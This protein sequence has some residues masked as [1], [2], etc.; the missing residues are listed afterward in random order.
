MQYYAG[1]TASGVYGG[2]EAIAN[3]YGLKDALTTVGMSFG[4]GYSKAVLAKDPLI[5]AK[6]P[7]TKATAH[8]VP[9]VGKGLIIKDG[10]TFFSGFKK[11]WNDYGR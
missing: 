1:K 9:F 7:I 8:F 6:K 11:G 4:D 2:C 5:V 3:D 10:I